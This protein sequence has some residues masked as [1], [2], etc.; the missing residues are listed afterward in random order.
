MMKAAIFYSDV[1]TTVSPTYAKEILTD[2]YGEGFTIY[3][4]NEKTWFY[5]VF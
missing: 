4:W 1:I 3:S 2:Q 5:M